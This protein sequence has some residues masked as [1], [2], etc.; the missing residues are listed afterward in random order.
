MKTY[1]MLL[2]IMSLRYVLQKCITKCFNTDVNL[3][4]NESIREPK[5]Y[6]GDF[7][8]KTLQQ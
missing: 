1:A 2:H 8:K 7:P 3:K 4:L 6:E 5:F